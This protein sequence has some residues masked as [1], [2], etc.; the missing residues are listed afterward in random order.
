[1]NG[2][3]QIS[4]VPLLYY[5]NILLRIYRDNMYIIS[6]CLD[7]FTVYIVVSFAY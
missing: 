4:S 1:M 7:K 5:I 3:E 2:T 6:L